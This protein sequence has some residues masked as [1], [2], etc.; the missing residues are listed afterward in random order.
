MEYPIEVIG[1]WASWLADQLA[2]DDPT[3]F[4]DF[5]EQPGYAGHDA[6]QTLEGLLFDRRGHIA[7]VLTTKQLRDLASDDPMWTINTAVMPDDMPLALVIDGVSG[8][9]DPRSLRGSC[10]RLDSGEGAGHELWIVGGV[11]PV[12]MVL[13]TGRRPMDTTAEIPAWLAGVACSDRVSL[14]NRRYV[15]WCHYHRHQVVD[16]HPGFG[17]DTL[18]GMP[19]H[20]QRPQLPIMMFSPFT[21]DFTGKMIIV[22]GAQDI[23]VWTSSMVDYHTRVA[24]RLG[25]RVDDHFRLWWIE[26]M[27]HLPASSYGV[28]ARSSQVIDYLGIIE[29]AVRD[30]IAWVEHGVSPPPTTKYHYTPDNALVL[31]PA[32][33]ERGGL[34]AV[35]QVAAIRQEGRK[36]TFRATAEVPAGAGV[37]VCIEWDPT[38]TGAWVPGASEYTHVYE[39]PGTYIAS[40]RVTSHREGNHDEPFGRVQALGRTRV[41][42]PFSPQ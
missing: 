15:A 4:S 26:R 13:P 29:Q 40:V 20:P 11:G 17:Q 32:A 3:Y 1:V 36:V 23:A 16:G 38:G 18:D 34:Q 12:L 41:I 33:A 22:Q 37:I 30:L 21:S 14:D 25:D 5:W 7:N 28:S 31:A 6:P 42:T 27:G 8:E 19:L 39:Q 2:R 24:A 9:I 35:V 10:V